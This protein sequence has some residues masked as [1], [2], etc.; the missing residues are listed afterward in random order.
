MDRVFHISWD[1][2][3]MDINVGVFFST[4][5]VKT[6]RKYFKLTEQDRKEEQKEELES[7]IAMEKADR[8][9]AMAEL[10]ELEA[11]VAA[12]RSRFPKEFT[13]EKQVE[14]LDKSLDLLREARRNAW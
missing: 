8:Q 6:I 14:K 3:H 13:L 2:G 1:R 11:R 4:A 5:N 7:M 9:K 10:E 12:I